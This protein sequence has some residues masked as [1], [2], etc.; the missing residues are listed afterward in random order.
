VPLELDGLGIAMSMHP[1]PSMQFSNAIVDEPFG[2]LTEPKNIHS[3]I[4]PAQTR[5]APTPPENY[6]AGFHPCH[7]NFSPNQPNHCGGV[8]RLQYTWLLL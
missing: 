8:A 5:P 6:L 3:W 1:K 7:A 4:L 2:E